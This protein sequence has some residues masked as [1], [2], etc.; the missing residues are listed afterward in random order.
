MNVIDKIY[1]DNEI[2]ENPAN[3]SI[4]WCEKDDCKLYEYFADINDRVEGGGVHVGIFEQGEN[5]KKWAMK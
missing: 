4:T 1:T 5:L 2:A 3:K